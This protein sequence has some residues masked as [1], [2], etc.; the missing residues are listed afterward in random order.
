MRVYFDKLTP[1]YRP[2]FRKVT[3]RAPLEIITVMQDT[4]YHVL[5]VKKHNGREHGGLKALH[6]SSRT[7]K[8]RTSRLLRA[9]S[10][11]KVPVVLNVRGEGAYAIE[12]GPQCVVWVADLFETSKEELNDVLRDTKLTRWLGGDPKKLAKQ[13]RALK[14]EL[15]D[16]ERSNSALS[17]ENARLSGEASR[18][19][20]AFQQERRIRLGLE[21]ENRLLKQRLEKFEAWYK[22][23]TNMGLIGPNSPM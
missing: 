15:E 19:K 14:K 9:A 16:I 23:D 1:D 21:S 5:T 12:P 4:E 17:D 18:V 3:E 8:D 11:L 6:I 13:V 10:V 2:Y 7:L 20:D 22:H